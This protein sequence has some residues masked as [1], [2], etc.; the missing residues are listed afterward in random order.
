VKKSIWLVA[1]ISIVMLSLI[2]LTA[3]C[4]KKEDIG[5]LT[6]EQIKAAKKGDLQAT[7]DF[8]Y[9][10]GMWSESKLPPKE[11]KR[12]KKEI[13]EGFKKALDIWINT[14]DN[15]KDFE[16]GLAGKALWELKQQT[17]AEQAQGKIKIRVHDKREFEVVKIKEDAG[18]VAYTY[19]DNSYYIDAKTK[20][21]I[22]KPTGDKKEWLIGIGKYGKVWKISEIVP[23]RPK[24]PTDKEHKSQ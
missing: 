23:L 22:S 7:H 19:V 18:A 6:D 4:Q 10:G 8:K 21:K 14:K 16:K 20:K 24:T 17:A 11:A 5:G 3:G 1:I 9:T 13:E 12:I 2:G 15:P